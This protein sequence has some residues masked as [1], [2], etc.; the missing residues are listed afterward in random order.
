MLGSTNV[1]HWNGSAWSAVP[2][3][4]GSALGDIWAVAPGDVWVAGGLQDVSTGGVV[5]YVFHFD[6]ATWTSTQPAAR[7]DFGWFGIWADA[8]SAWAVG[9]G[10]RIDHFTSGTWSPVQAPQG[11]SEGFVDVV[12]SGADT[13]AAGQNLV[14]SVA[15]GPFVRDPDVPS[16]AIL[17]TVWLTPTEV[18]TAGS[19]GVSHTAL[20]LH[21][22]R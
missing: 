3:S 19:N 20:V 2:G 18:W 12:S 7:P 16:D 9:E 22:P 1:F 21:R 4:P 8:T 10:E 11:S 6:G 14:H 17:P 13:Y 15:G 5:S